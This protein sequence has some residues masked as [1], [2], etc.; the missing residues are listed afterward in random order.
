MVQDIVPLLTSGDLNELPQEEGSTLGDGRQLG[1]VLGL[2][3]QTVDLHHVQTGLLSM[4]GSKLFVYRRKC[5][6]VLCYAS[7]PRASG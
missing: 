2:P 5:L 6:G 7:D 1:G 4:A 3:L